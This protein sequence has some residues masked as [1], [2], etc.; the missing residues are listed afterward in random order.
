MINNKLLAI[1]ATVFFAFCFNNSYADKTEPVNA[2]IENYDTKI[3]IDDKGYKIH[4]YKKIVLYNDN[5]IDETRIQLY[6]SGMDESKLIKA[7]VRDLSDKLIR[8]IKSSDLNDYGDFSN[9]SSDAHVKFYEFSDLTFPCTIETEYEYSAHY[10]LYFPFWEPVTDFNV[11]V[12]DASLQI[13]VE[14]KTGL[15]YKELNMP[16]TVEVNLVNNI[17][18]YTWKL[19]DFKPLKEEKYID[20]MSLPFPKVLLAPSALNYN[21]YSGKFETWSDLGNWILLLNAQRDNLDEQTTLKVKEIAA[22]YPDDL[23]KM[24]AIYEFMQNTTRYV[25]IQYGIG[26]FQ[27]F[28]ASYVAEKGYGDCKALSNYMYT[29][30]KAA[31]IKSYYTLVLAGKNKSIYSDFPAVQFNHVILCVPNNGDTLWLENTDQKIPFA[32]LGDFTDDRDVLVMA[33][34]PF[35]THTKKYTKQENKDV[36]TATVF[37]QENGD[38]TINLQAKKY[39]LCMRELYFLHNY[40]TQKEQMMYLSSYMPLKNSQIDSFSLSLIKDRNP[41]IAISC[42]INAEKYASRTGSRLFIPLNQLEK[43]PYTFSS[44]TIRKYPVFQ[45]KDCEIIDSIKFYIPEGYTVESTPSMFKD[46]T[47]FSNYQAGWTI[48]QNEIIYSRNLAINKAILDTTQYQEIRRYYNSLALR[49]NPMVV[50]KRN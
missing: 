34:K 14:G 18:T 7:E 16:K 22:K 49:D 8:K 39:A 12:K 37:I 27:P 11:L 19:V 43:I 2:V 24:K 47:G 6:H 44:D 35:L 25:S 3:S 4:V 1:Y 41:Y 29:L 46:S 42:S 9:F 28:P 45:S 36:T 10:L 50:L 30:L 32:Y 13:S 33:D 5:A 31:G 23:N 38:A 17:K 15:R 21:S 48:N 40:Y 26:G 20:E